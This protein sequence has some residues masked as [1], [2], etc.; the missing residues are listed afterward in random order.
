ME[1]QPAVWLAPQSG[2]GFIAMA[3]CSTPI[4][5]AYQWL[6][7]RISLI[8]IGSMLSANVIRI[9]TVEGIFSVL[10]HDKPSWDCQTDDWA[11]FFWY[12][13]PRAL[14]FQEQI[15]RQKGL[16]K[17][18]PWQMQARCREVSKLHFL[19][20]PGTCSPPGEYAWH[21][22]SGQGASLLLWSSSFAQ[23]ICHCWPKFEGSPHCTATL[24]SSTRREAQIVSQGRN[25]A[26]EKVRNRAD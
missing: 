26:R 11:L 10:L 8:L 17:E 19:W 14:D 15:Q 12:C 1:R 4:S 16:L 25:C 3:S 5:P 13:R 6:L 20:R 22:L 2:V 23:N 18:I 21:L 9:P 7:A 24:C